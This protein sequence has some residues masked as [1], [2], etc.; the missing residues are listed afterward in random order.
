MGSSRAKGYTN[1]RPTKQSQVDMIEWTRQ[2]IAS[3]DEPPTARY[4]FYKLV[5]QFGFDKTE[6]AYARLCE[7]LVKARRAGLIDFDAIRDEKTDTLGGDS[8]YRDPAEFWDELRESASYYGRRR[9]EGQPTRI[10][11]WCETRGMGP[12]LAKV[13]RRYGVQVFATGGFPGVTSTHAF[14]QRVIASNRPTVF[15]H[16]GDYDPS[17]EAIYEAIRDDTFAFVAGELGL[18]QARELFIAERIGLTADQVLEHEIET[19]PPKG[20][21]SRSKRWEEEGNLDSAQLEAVDTDLYRSWAREAIERHTDMDLMQ[22]VI[23]RADREREKIN[24]G[25]DRL[26]AEFDEEE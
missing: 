24:T 17:G 11:L 25:L 26:F 12:G 13:A 4:V 8:G 7:T 5:G 1:W 21:D 14:A 10:E 16:L 6:K 22:E 2:V 19:V 3:E 15:L 18:P 23:E 20:S 9:R